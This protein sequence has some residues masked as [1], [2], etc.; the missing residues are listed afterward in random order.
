MNFVIDRRASAVLFDGVCADRRRCFWR[1]RQSRL[2]VLQFRSCVTART[3]TSRI[4]DITDIN[5]VSEAESVDE[6]DEYEEESYVG[7][8]MDRLAP[9]ERLRA[10]K[11]YAQWAALK[12][13]KLTWIVATSFL[14]LAFPLAVSMEREASLIELDKQLKGQGAPVGTFPEPAQ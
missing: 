13:G 4:Q 6:Y 14:V 10:A 3:M 8:I 11:L 2:A 12:A 7:R 1:S 5:D 9:A